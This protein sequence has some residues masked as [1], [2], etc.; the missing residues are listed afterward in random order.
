MPHSYFS[1]T[2]PRFSEHIFLEPLLMA[3]C[4]SPYDSFYP[5]R[6][7]GVASVICSICN[8]LGINVFKQYFYIQEQTDLGLPQHVKCNSL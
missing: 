6:L 7:S 1:M 3:V 2:L 4:D 8:T 5:K